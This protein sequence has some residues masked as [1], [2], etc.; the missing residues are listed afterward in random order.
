MQ[1]LQGSGSSQLERPVDVLIASGNLR[2][3]KYL[4]AITMGCPVL[5]S[6]WLQA[7]SVPSGQGIHNSHCMNLPGT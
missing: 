2:S 6:S 3:A 7:S 4:A 1:V 5:D